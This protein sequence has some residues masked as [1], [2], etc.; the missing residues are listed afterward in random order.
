MRWTRAL[1]A[2]LLGFEGFL[3]LRPDGVLVRAAQH[4]HRKEDDQA[5]LWWRRSPVHMGCSVRSCTRTATRTATYRQMSPRGAIWRAY[6]FCEA[7]D[8]P[9]TL[10]GLVYRLGQPEQPGYDVPLTPFW[11]EVYFLLGIL[12]FGI[13]CACVWR[14]ATPRTGRAAWSCLLVLQAVVVAGFWIY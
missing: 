14:Y 7:H 4:G 13:W 5:A 1:L 9:Q 10:T 3:L 6:G 2:V 11:T 8:P 12:A